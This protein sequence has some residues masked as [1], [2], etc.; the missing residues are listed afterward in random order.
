MDYR[1]LIDAATLQ[2]QLGQ[3]GWVVLDCRFTLGDPD[4]GF[5]AYR[6]GHIPGA[7]YAHLETDLSGP[8]AGDTGRHPLP[9]PAVLARRLGA[10]GIDRVS[11]VVVYDDV[12]GAMAARAWWLLRWLGHERVALL[13]GGLM[14][15]QRAGGAL[16]QEAPAVA[17]ARFD[18][19]PGR[20]E[21]VDT[22]ALASQL[23]AFA[24]RLVDARAA[25]RFRGEQE[26]I[27]PV[28]GHVPGALNRPF[29]D[30][31]DGGYFKPAATLRQEWQA[32][33]DGQAPEAMV[34]M[35]GSGVTACHHLLALEVAG[36]GGAQLYPGSWSE[37]IRDRARPVA[38]GDARKEP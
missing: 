4:A 9:A 16:G 17:P 20:C 1:T 6:A 32:L 30:N 35:C 31:L 36:L 21:T 7:R 8:V 13:D 11:Q 18:A 25:A 38:T 5:Q 27:D 22:Q 19:E 28:A 33:L 12:G 29:Q 24:G 2:R 23:S 3:P 14:A 10:W 26:P 37:W 34:M 15:W